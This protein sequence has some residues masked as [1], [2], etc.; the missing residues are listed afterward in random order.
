MVPSVRFTLRIGMSMRT[1]SLSSKAGC[2]IS[3]SLLSNALSSSW[4][5]SIVL[6]RI[7]PGIGPGCIST[8]LRSMPSDFQ[9]LIASFWSRHSTWPTASSSVWKPSWASSSRTSC[10]M[11]MK[12]LITCSGLPLNR[13][14]NSGS[15]VAMPCGQVFF[16]QA[17]I[18]TQPSTISAAVAKPNSS[19]PSRAAITTSRPVFNSP[20][21]CTVMRERRP[22]RTSVCWVSDRPISHGVP[23]CLMALSG[24]A[25]VP[26]S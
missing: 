17:R 2:A 10:A 5:W 16:W 25:P 13:A 9:R 18:M 7:V 22:F 15:C 1:G 6:C 4:F 8:L 12:K 11:N 19:A 3:I 21:H 14:R 26:P 20:S 24:A 23:A